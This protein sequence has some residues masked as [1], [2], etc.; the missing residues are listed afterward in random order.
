MG[1]LKKLRIAATA[2]C[3]VA[4]ASAPTYADMSAFNTAVRA[5]DYRTAAAA[6]RAA[7]PTLDSSNPDMANIAREFAWAAMRGGDAENAQVYAGFLV[8]H[9]AKLQPPDSMPLTSAVLKAWADFALSETTGTREAF[10]KSLSAR[11]EGPGVDIIS[12]AAAESFYVRSVQIQNWQDARDAART[13]AQ[14]AERGKELTMLQKYRAK[15]TSLAAEIMLE[16][17]R[18]AYDQLVELDKLFHNEAT[19]PANAANGKALWALHDMAL[20]WRSALGPAFPSLQK[21][22]DSERDLHEGVSARFSSP[23]SGLPLC[24]LD[25]VRN[26]DRLFDAVPLGAVGAV[27][28]DFAIDKD[29]RVLNAKVLAAVPTAALNEIVLKAAR[30]WRYKIASGIDHAT[31]ELPRAHYVTTVNYHSR[32]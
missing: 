26:S 25:A 4:V 32:N 11:L 7:W 13:A 29:G 31:C 15:V 19:Q 28:V 18:P 17:R 1:V 9:G 3:I 2:L 23:A 20:A 6:A 24:K 5:A 27:V 30:N 22:P 14:L 16:P 12:L 10:V 8:E 21:S